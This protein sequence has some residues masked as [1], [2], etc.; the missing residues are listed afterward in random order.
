M[1]VTVAVGVYVG[2]P[3]GKVFVAVGVTLGVGVSVGVDAG[4]M[5][6]RKQPA[7]SV[8]PIMALVQEQEYAVLN[9]PLTS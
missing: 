7:V 2:T 6:H 8:T 4:A 9:D 3:V 5:S 1:G